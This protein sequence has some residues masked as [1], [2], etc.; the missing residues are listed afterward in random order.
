MID[1]L[2]HDVGRSTGPLLVVTGAGIS[3]ASGIPTFRGPDPG[4]VWS[5]DVTELGTRRYFTRDPAG[6]WRWY[7]A[8]FAGVHGR[9]PNDAHRALVALER[10]KRGDPPKN[11]FVLV[12]QNIDGLHRAA[13]SEQLVEVHGSAHHVRCSVDGCVHGAPQG[14][15]PFSAV[16]FTAF[17]AD[18]VAANVPPCP[19]C[20]APL[21]PHV[22]WFDE[23]YGEHVSY[24]YDAV[25]GAARQA[26]VMIFVGTSFSV[27][28]TAALLDAGAARGIPTWS[29][30]PSGERPA[31]HVRV[32]AEKAEIALPALCSRL[33]R[34]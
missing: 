8:R 5:V 14:T 6:S 27:G 26:T 24:R 19:A 31:P 23:Y 20:G 17:D 12:T 2:A 11:N 1:A 15:L 4:A 7:R 10:W 9:E 29:I 3:L 22:L 30:D 18:P 32:L 16:D 21:R 34:A 33:R 25:A 13:G 28:V